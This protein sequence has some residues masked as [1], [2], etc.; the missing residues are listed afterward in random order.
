M[1]CIPILLKLY[2]AQAETVPMIYRVLIIAAVS[3][4]FFWGHRCASFCHAFGG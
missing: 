1:P 3:M 2:Q 4:P